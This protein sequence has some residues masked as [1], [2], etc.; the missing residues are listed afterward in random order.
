MERNRT[1][2]VTYDIRKKNILA[3][4]NTANQNYPYEAYYNFC[5]V[6][7]RFI[8]FL[9]RAVIAGALLIR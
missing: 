8:A 9:S 4:A 2:D 7:I 6:E 1:D 3:Y 5:Y